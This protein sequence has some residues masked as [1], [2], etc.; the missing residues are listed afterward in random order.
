LYENIW[1]KNWKQ[2]NVI[3]VFDA[4]IIF[5]LPE[6]VTLFCFLLIQIAR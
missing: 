4:I 1:R 6:N 2:M 5:V 3:S